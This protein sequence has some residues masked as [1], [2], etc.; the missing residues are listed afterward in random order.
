MVQIHTDYAKVPVP[1]SEI[2][3]VRMLPDGDATA[4]VTRT[5]GET[6]RG[7]GRPTKSPCIWK[8]S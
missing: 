1:L 3:E 8:S 6:M 4:V 5:N 2:K 7:R